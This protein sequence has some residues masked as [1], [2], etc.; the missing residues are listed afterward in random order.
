MAGIRRFNVSV[1]FIAIF[2]FLGGCASGNK[3]SSST[4]TVIEDPTSLTSDAKL[5][6]TQTGNGID[7][8]PESWS[9]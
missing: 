5:L 1:F 6:G 3:A 2:G 7:L 9:V 4:A 8:P